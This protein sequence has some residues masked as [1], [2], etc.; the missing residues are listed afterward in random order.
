MSDSRRWATGT[1]VAAVV[2]GMVGA[3]A[4]AQ[5]ITI[6]KTKTSIADLAKSLG[7]EKTI[8]KLAAFQTGGFG[9]HGRQLDYKTKIILTKRGKVISIVVPDAP[10]CGGVVSPS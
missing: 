10:G 6:I 9:S 5:A 2:A 7:L 3:A 4:P 8:T 1:A